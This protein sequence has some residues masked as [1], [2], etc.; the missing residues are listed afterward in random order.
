MAGIAGWAIPSGLAARRGQD[1]RALLPMA[2][3]LS[4]RT[5][6]GESLLACVDQR[7]RQQL[8]MSASLWDRRA[9]IAIAL[10]GAFSNGAELRAR[11]ARGGFRLGEGSDAELLMRAYQYWDKDAVR[12]LRGPFAL[13]LW[14]S[15][16][17]RLMLARDRFGER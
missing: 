3:A 17:D 10:D 9:G 12:H 13:A 8:V 15:H 14:D 5:G 4:H 11:L 6:D 2:E 7:R 16:K 1:E